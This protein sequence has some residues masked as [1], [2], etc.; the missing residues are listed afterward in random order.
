MTDTT[1]SAPDAFTEGTY[2]PKSY[3]F[4]RD[5]D[6]SEHTKRYDT[7]RFE[8][9]SNT[10]FTYSNMSDLLE[11]E[12]GK[13]TLQEIIRRFM[14][15]QKERIEILDD[16]SKGDNY[17]VLNGRRRLE[18]EKSDY[19][20]RHNW[21]GYISGFITGNIFGKPVTVGLAEGAESDDL[22]DIQ[23]IIEENDLDALNYELGFDTSRFGRAFELHYR[24][25][26]KVD[27]IVLIDPTEMFVIRDETV[28]NEIIGAVHCPV[29][30]GK[31]YVTIYT[32]KQA[33]ALKPT[34]QSLPKI[35]EEQRTEHY[36]D[37]VPVVEWWGNRFR[38]GD[39]E[40]EIPLIDAYDAAQSDT[41]NY[42]SDLND[43]LLVINGDMNASGLTLTDAEKMKRANMLL[44]ETGVGVDGKQTSL[45]AGYIYKQ[46]DVAGTEAYKKR[47][48][49]D[50]Y[51][52]SN[53][54]N[55]EDDKFNSTQS[56]IALKYKMLGLGQK[57]ATKISFYKK[58][59]RRRFRLIQNVHKNLSDVEID[60]SKLTF[61]FHENLPQDVWAEVK[62]YI[63]SGGEVSQQ[64]LRDLATF[65]TNELETDRLDREDTEARE[66][67]MT[68]EEKAEM[69]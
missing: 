22:K 8:E 41:A 13:K 18:E 52:L 63:D 9:D 15:S 33:I 45:T 5:M 40:N 17:T 30:N 59:L 7:I 28:A 69:G 12:D 29:Y 16:Y 53:V 3:Q 61:V 4:E 21:G 46:Y 36:Y 25:A 10:H 6:V 49:N 62:Q 39:F 50:I 32:D 43:A 2:I 19:R 47:I 34:E 42:M 66:P 31:L 38:Q 55:L 57:R 58:A 60:V 27:R 68:D 23:S 64:T 35:E 26:D 67:L 44:L 24:D 54:P 14:Y 65:T 20:I 56:G 1:H 37:D 51:N 48:V 11:T